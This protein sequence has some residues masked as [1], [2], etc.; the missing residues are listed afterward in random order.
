MHSYEKLCFKTL[1]S[2][3]KLESLIGSAILGVLCLL[4]GMLR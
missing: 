2:C 1:F 4:A 3:E